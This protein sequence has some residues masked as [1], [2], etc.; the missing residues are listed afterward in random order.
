M[1]RVTKV[2]RWVRGSLNIKRLQTHVTLKI[3]ALE[4]IY[5]KHTLLMFLPDCLIKATSGSWLKDM[6]LV[7]VLYHYYHFFASEFISEAPR[8]SAFSV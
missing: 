3:N 8:K 4:C 5:Q 6:H 1:N 7:F 2:N